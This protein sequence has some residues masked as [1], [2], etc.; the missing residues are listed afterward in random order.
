MGLSF[1]TEGA[2]PY[3]AGH[4]LQVIPSCIVGSA[5]A[6]ALSALFGCQLMAPHG[7]IFVFA[8]MQGTWYWYILALAVGAVVSMLM[9]A[10]LK[11]K[12]K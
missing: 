4:P 1:I 8:T 2:I 6:G 9:L 11:K 10:L 5:C 12:V 3:A 7:G